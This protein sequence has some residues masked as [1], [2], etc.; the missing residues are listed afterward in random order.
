[1]P[2]IAEVRLS[3]EF[4][5]RIGKTYTF[6]KIEKSPV[7]KIKTDLKIPYTSFNIHSESRGKEMLICLVDK[8]DIKNMKVT[9][10]MSGRW[11]FYDP[12]DSINEKIHKHTHLRFYTSEDKILGLCDVR[13]F[14]KWSWS[15][16]DTKGRGPCIFKET[17]DFADNLRDNWF[18]HKD[19]KKYKLSEI[20]MNQKW[21]NG[22][23]NYLRAE[24]LYRLDKNPFMVASELKKEDLE[25][26]IGLTIG[27]CNQSY[28]L[29]GGQLKDWKNPNGEN[30]QSFEEWMKCYS[31]LEK[32]LDA[33]GR[34]FWF[35]KKWLNQL[36]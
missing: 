26:L 17:L 23:G 33:S 29:G 25:N 34:T 8:T 28:A 7:S 3:S 18:N 1:M 11:V 27:C 14:A 35:D 24:I 20:M 30:P 22:V 19:F 4:V 15:N 2:E 9:L 12:L 36:I 10:G 6:T 5:D 21:F 13:R 16:F 31:K 32:T